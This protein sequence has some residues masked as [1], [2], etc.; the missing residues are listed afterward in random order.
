MTRWDGA[1]VMGRLTPTTTFNSN[2]RFFIYR[3]LDETVLDEYVL[4]S[5]FMIRDVVNGT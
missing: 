3:A 4:H 1:G 5:I 2:A